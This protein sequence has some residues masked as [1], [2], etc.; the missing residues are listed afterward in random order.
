[1]EYE[2]NAGRP[3]Q[4]IDEIDASNEENCNGYNKIAMTSIV[5]IYQLVLGGIVHLHFIPSDDA[6]CIYTEKTYLN[7]LLQM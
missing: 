6:A 4:C 2:D 1:M 5:Y 7:N 3:T